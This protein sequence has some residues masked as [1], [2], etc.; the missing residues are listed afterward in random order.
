MEGGFQRDLAF[1]D[2]S[3][4]DF[5]E[6]MGRSVGEADALHLFIE[7]GLAPIGIAGK[8][9]LVQLGIFFQIST[10]LI[11]DFFVGFF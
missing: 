10:D 3:S 6:G 9:K 5:M 4:D 8:R 2:Q 7:S 11:S 1:F